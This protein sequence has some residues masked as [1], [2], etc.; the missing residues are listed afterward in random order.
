MYTGVAAWFFVS[1]LF[2]LFFM[3]VYVRISLFNTYVNT[4]LRMVS[5]LARQASVISIWL[6]SLPC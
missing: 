1:V 4:F 3:N 5:H 2:C 6:C